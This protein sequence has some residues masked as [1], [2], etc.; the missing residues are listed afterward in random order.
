LTPL[1][2]ILLLM[3]K[4]FDIGAAHIDIADGEAV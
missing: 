3:V 2:L 1:M 4:L